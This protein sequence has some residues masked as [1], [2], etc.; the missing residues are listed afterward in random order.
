M[1]TIVMKSIAAALIALV[2]AGSAQAV[3]VS[4]SF[5]FTATGLPISPIVG[6]VSYSFDNTAGFFNAANGATANGSPVQVSFTGLNNLPG[7]WTPVL[8]YV[9][10][11]NIGGNPVADLMSI[12]H[13]LN[14]TATTMGT[15]DWRIAFNTISTAPGFREFTYTQASAPGAQFQTFA[16]SVTAVPEPTTAAFMGL[17]LAVLLAA[18]RRL[19]AEVRL[20]PGSTPMGA[21]S[22][23][24]A[25]SC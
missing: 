24:G 3:V 20:R 8:T 9:L 4:G 16:G 1:R 11:G 6:T 22:T 12:G 10:S 2:G 5:S 18:R 14:G 17:G 15:D 25:A 7:S 13:T 21:S 23:A 19:S